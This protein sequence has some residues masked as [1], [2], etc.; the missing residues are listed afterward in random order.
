MSKSP[1]CPPNSAS[2][3]SCLQTPTM[4]LSFAG[5][6]NTFLYVTFFQV[7]APLFQFLNKLVSSPS[8]G[9]PKAIPSDKT[10]YKL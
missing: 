3:L 8:Q 5:H 10:G 7:L 2:L 9:F 6:L 4:S 1:D